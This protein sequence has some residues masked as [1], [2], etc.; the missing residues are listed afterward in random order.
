[1]TKSASRFPDPASEAADPR[2]AE[3]TNRDDGEI[4]VRE[5]L[6]VGGRRGMTIEEMFPT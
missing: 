4:S 6:A 3:L 5:Y 1:M 2:G